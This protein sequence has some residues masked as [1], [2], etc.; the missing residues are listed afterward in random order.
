MQMT[1]LKL[2]KV[3]GF[4][5][6]SGGVWALTASS[7]CFWSTS[8]TVCLSSDRSISSTVACIELPSVFVAE[9]SLRF[10]LLLDGPGVGLPRFVLRGAVVPVT[11]GE[12]SVK[13]TNPFD[14][15]EGPSWAREE[16]MLSPPKLYPKLLNSVG[17]SMLSRKLRCGGEGSAG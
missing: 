9:P 13:S 2:L 8:C 11:S 10:A 12:S 6:S 7:R 4:S 5:P 1:Q 14:G 3:I 16:G 17:L 15:R